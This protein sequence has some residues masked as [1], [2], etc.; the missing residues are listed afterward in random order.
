[1]DGKCVYLPDYWQWFSCGVKGSGDRR[2][3]H[4]TSIMTSVC[5]R[6]FSEAFRTPSMC[7]TWIVCPVAS[8]TFA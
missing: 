6:L 7:R 8:K 1:M 2:R 5:R 3:M 4:G